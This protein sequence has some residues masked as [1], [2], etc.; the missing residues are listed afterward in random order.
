MDSHAEDTVF[1]Q[2]NVLVVENLLFRIWVDRS[3]TVPDDFGQE[4][5]DEDVA[6]CE[7]TFHHFV[8]FQLLVDTFEVFP[9]ESIF[10]VDWSQGFHR[11]P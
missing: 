10:A 7:L 9:E 6:S 4:D 5:T 11:I 3:E 2:V 1:S 8:G